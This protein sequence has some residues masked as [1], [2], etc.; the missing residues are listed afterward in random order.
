MAPTVD[1]ALCGYWAE[2][3]DVVGH[4]RSLLACRRV[5]HIAIGSLNQVRPLAHRFDIESTLTQDA[6]DLLR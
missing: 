5:E 2:I 3:L 6:R 1:E 4:D